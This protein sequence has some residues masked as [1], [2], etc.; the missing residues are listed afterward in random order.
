MK[1]HLVLELDLEWNAQLSRKLVSQ[2]GKNSLN[3]GI[4]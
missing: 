1:E 3:L 2:S 4:Q